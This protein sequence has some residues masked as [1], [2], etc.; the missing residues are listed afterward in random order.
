MDRAKDAHRPVPRADPVQLVQ[1]S[2]Q[3]VTMLPN[4]AAGRGPESM[5]T[6]WMTVGQLGCWMASGGGRGRAT[7]LRIRTVGRLRFHLRLAMV[8]PGE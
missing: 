6:E 7:T 4:M 1:E 2:L 8:D 3:L 5:T